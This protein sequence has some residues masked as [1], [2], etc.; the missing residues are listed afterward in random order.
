[1]SIEV[2][3]LE[4][5]F[6]RTSSS[7][8]C[9]FAVRLYMLTSWRPAGPFTV[10]VSQTLT[11]KNTSSLPLAFKVR[12]SRAHPTRVLCDLFLLPSTALM[13][14]TLPATGENHRSQ[15]VRLGCP[16][17]RHAQAPVDLSS[18][19]C[20]RP[21]AGR[22][23]PGHDFDVSGAYTSTPSP[24]ADQRAQHADPCAVLLQA[25]KT[26]P[27]ADVKCRDKFLVQSAPISVEKDFASISEVVCHRRQL[28]TSRNAANARSSTTRIRASCRRKRFA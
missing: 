3:P 26:D 17:L 20:V 18:R 23:E 9:L 10:E 21:N 15:T 6:R 2:E 27:A 25:M 8:L 13:L 19:Y 24:S 11:I 14:T 7:I 22:I 5:N 12:L 1:M 16:R 4:L 28:P